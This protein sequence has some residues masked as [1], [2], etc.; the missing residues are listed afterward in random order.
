MKVDNI[1][2][3]DIPLFV[4]HVYFAITPTIDDFKKAKIGKEYGEGFKLSEAELITKYQNYNGECF[5]NGGIIVIALYD[6]NDKYSTIPHESSHAAR[7]ILDNIR[8]KE[9]DDEVFA[10][11]VGYISE[12]C[13]EKL[14]K[15]K[16]LNNSVKD[17]K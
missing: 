13:F 14:E 6:L 5:F 1:F 12:F 3:L 2:K 8:V 7:H 15:Y 10:Y 17:K 11:L 4:S 9:L 16:N